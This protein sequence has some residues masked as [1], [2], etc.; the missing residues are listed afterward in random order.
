MYT[1]YRDTYTM[2]PGLGM[3]EIITFVWKTLPN[4]SGQEPGWCRQQWR[5][6]TAPPWSALRMKRWK[7]KPY[8]WR[9]MFWED[10][11]SSNIWYLTAYRVCLLWWNGVYTIMHGLAWFNKH[12]CSFIWQKPF[13]HF[14]ENVKLSQ[15]PV[16]RFRGVCG[17]TMEPSQVYAQ[18]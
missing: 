11:L 10:S 4:I 8:R 16:D 1:A 2:N 3:V 18:N 15:S 12:F 7:T 14:P 13:W 9:L 17:T 5:L 6:P